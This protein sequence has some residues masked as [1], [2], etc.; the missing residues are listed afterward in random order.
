MR[1]IIASSICLVMC[2]AQHTQAQTT[3]EDILNRFF[4]LYEKTNSDS[5]LDYVF[6]TNKFL[7]PEKKVLNEIKNK[8]RNVLTVVG[9]YHGYEVIAKKFLGNSYCQY[10]FM[11]KYDRQPIQFT[12]ILY[13]PDKIWQVHNLRFDDKLDPELQEAPNMAKDGK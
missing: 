5:A 3:P 12:F 4:F 11:V 10:S 7:D 9:D 13:K 1:F 8:L 2:M 6:G